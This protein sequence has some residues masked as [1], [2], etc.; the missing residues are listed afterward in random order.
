MNLFLSLIGLMLGYPIYIIT[1]K[2]CFLN[3]LTRKEI[4]NNI[5]K[6]IFVSPS[7]V[8]IY[9]L[10]IYGIVLSTF[11]V[12]Y[13]LF[14]EYL[15]M[16]FLFIIF[17]H[18][19]NKIIKTEKRKLSYFIYNSFVL[20]QVTTVET[21]S[22]NHPTWILFI[23]AIL[24]PIIIYLLYYIFIT[25]SI[26]CINS[27]IQSS[28][29]VLINIL[30]FI[31]EILIC[32]LIYFEGTIFAKTTNNLQ[33][34][35]T[36]ILMCFIV[37]NYLFIV[38]EFV[39][40]YIILLNIRNTHNLLEL[41]KELFKNQEQIILTLAKTTEGKSED[42]GLHIKRVSEYC[43]AI[44]LENGYSEQEAEKIRMASILHDV[45]KIAIPDDILNKPAKLTPEEFDIVK[46]HVIKGEEMIHELEGDIMDIAKN[47]AL[48]HHEKWDGTGY[49]GLKG[50]EIT[51]E[52]R[53]AAVA[54]VF[55]A[56]SSKR[57]YKDD[58]G[59]DKAKEIIIEGKG[60]HF[61]P[62]IVNNFL[63]CYDK[64]IQINNSFK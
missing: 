30:P 34:T 22:A 49:L 36:S 5:L 62:K 64:I 56:I 21:I 60:K 33:K 43:K 46:T 4:K 8:Y 18:L 37:I 55:D 28:Q 2:K 6:L 41:N 40:Y 32:M 23:S 52:A 58:W 10:T 15:L 1:T 51:K 27:D 39:A 7:S 16:I 26:Q 12:E 35:P 47:I 11:N 48:E 31:A 17:M 54:D 44:A 59:T 25:K 29:V 38:F 14:I 3:N 57:C 19:Y 42:T 45:G 24:C 9:S 61:D 50:E 13:N 20:V 53:I 63:N